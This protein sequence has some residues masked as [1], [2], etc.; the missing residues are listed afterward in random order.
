MVVQIYWHSTLQSMPGYENRLLIVS[1]FFCYF[2]HT[3]VLRAQRTSWPPFS[4]SHLEVINF[5]EK[6]IA[7]CN[8]RWKSLNISGIKL[9]AVQVN[10]IVILP[11]YME[12]FPDL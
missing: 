5:S 12:F 1:L 8:L 9:T 3:E 11:D 2:H 4:P 7:R 6:I 10:D